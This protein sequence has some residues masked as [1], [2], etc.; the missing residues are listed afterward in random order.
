MVARQKE[1]AFA[2]QHPNPLHYLRLHCARGL[3]IYVVAKLLK[4]FALEMPHLRHI[5]FYIYA[6]LACSF[7]RPSML[8][9][10]EPWVVS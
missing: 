3:V 9:V 6:A 2:S 1:S 8:S 4:Q 7:R 5:N 10:G